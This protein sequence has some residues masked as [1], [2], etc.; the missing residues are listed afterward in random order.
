MA[1]KSSIEWT[2]ATW[3]PWHGCKKISP[4]CKNCYMYR[5]KKRYGQN[6]KS[7]LRSKSTFSD[8]LKWLEP[9]IIFTCS[10]SDFFI[11]EADTWRQ[12]AWEI[13]KATPQHTYQILTKRPERISN[14]L[15]ADWGIGWSH[16]WLGVS[17]ENQNYVQR[18]ETLLAVPAQTRFI[19]AEPLIGPLEFGN[20]H[21]IH[22][23]ITGGE[24]GPNARAMDLEWVRSIRD[25]C[26][27]QKIFF[28]HKQNGGRKRVDGTWGGRLLDGRT[29]DEFPIHL[30]I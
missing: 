9:K 20:L 13:I 23:I 7:V 24:S 3:N 27:R 5:D 12:E 2:E 29:W 21:G 1:S 22:W 4:G 26:K 15:P 30:P 14:H 6:P 28:F 11:E 25:Q 18:K 10:W 19:S 16:V 8:P 17:I